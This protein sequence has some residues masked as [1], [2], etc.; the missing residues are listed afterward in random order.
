MGSARSAAMRA[1]A[2]R[3]LTKGA[4]AISKGVG[5]IGILKEV[6][7]IVGPFLTHREQRDFNLIKTSRNSLERDEVIRR[8][9]GSLAR[10]LE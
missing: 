8:L 6:W 3:M 9:S 7:E 1:R 4:G 10:N 2:K 5:A